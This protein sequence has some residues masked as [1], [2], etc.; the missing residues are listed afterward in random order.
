MNLP[1][2]RPSM[3]VSSLIVATSLF[4]GWALAGPVGFVQ[5]SLASNQP[6]VAQFTDSSLLNPWGLISTATS[7]FWLGVNG[8]GISE[9]YNGAGVKQS[10][11]VTIPGNGSVTGVAVANVALSFNGD[12]FL[13]A[14][15]DGTVSGWRGALGTNAE[16][17]VVADPNNVYK[18][19]TEATIGGNA[20]AF[21]ANFHT[22]T[23]DVLKGNSSAPD[24]PGRFTDPGLP[25]GYAPFNVMNLGGQ[26]YVTYAQQDG[27]GHDDVP[28]AGHGFVSV[29]DL[30]GN[31]LR[32]IA[33]QG[34]LD[35]PWGLALAPAGFGDVG[36]SL[37]VGNFGDGTIHA[38]DP[39][40]G[41]LLETLMDAS[42]NPL[43]IDGLWA[44]QFG[45]GSGSGPTSTLFFTAGPDDES[46]GL[47]GSL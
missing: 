24:L 20:Y 32:R 33:S 35:S 45:N 19:L 4:A 40:S 17:L 44:L 6:G 21:L 27:T 30:N 31:F 36:G 7:P 38:Y 8:S 22:G 39:T 37:L 12:A 34:P 23:I 10:L 15:E 28:G 41:Q 18:G 25:S 5:T 1:R 13:F 29:F 26:I 42:G 46:N 16:R 47:F 9:L 14:S 3:R 2:R 43:M 11:V